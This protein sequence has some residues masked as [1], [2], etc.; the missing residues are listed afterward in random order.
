MD[1][2]TRREERRSK[3]SGRRRAEEHKTGFSSKCYRIPDGHKLFQVK[4]EGVKRLDII[5]YTVS[6]N[7]KNPYAEAGEQHFERTYF[8]HRDVGPD[9]DMYPCLQKTFGMSC[10]ICEYRK[11]LLKDPDADEDVIKNLA[12]K[13]RQLWNVLDLDEPEKGVQLWDCSFHLFGKQL[14][15]RIN[16]SDEDEGYEFFADPDEGLTLKIGFSEQSF[17]KSTFYQAETIDFK[18]RKKPIEDEVLEKAL[19]LDEILIKYDPQKLKEVFLQTKTEDADADESP[20]REPK[21][22]PAAEEDDEAPVKRRRPE[23]RDEEEE[24]TP[25]KR[26]GKPEEKKP[27]PSAEKPSERPK[28]KESDV[29]KP[30]SPSSKLKVK[31]NDVVD[32]DEW[33]ECSVIKISSDGTAVYILD[34]QDKKHSVDPSELTVVEFED[35]PEEEKP[36]PKK[37]S[38]DKTEPASK[39]KAPPKEEPEEEEGEVEEEDD[40]DWDDDW[41]DDK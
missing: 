21:K 39:K 1:R 14:D 40:A 33:G 36:A 20:I 29:A 24:E 27:A 9:A 22:K 11:N 34:K 30:A 32:H 3:V 26:Q 35:E 25:P 18:A 7:A 41:D 16:N 17:G 13:E 12:P 23:P 28:T 10:P 19:N 15:A 4:A 31:V 2:K 5:P 6:E 8:A 37:K 38:A